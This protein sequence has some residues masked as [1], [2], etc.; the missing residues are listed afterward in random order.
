M[1][2][3]IIAAICIVVLVISLFLAYKGGKSGSGMLDC[4]CVKAGGTCSQE[5]YSPGIRSCSIDKDTK[6]KCCVKGLG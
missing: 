6:G 4:E 3:L 5:G 2:V 1:N